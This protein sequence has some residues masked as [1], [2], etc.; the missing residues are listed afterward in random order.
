MKLQ[1]IL[2]VATLVVGLGVG[3]AAQKPKTQTATGPVLKIAGDSLTID[4]GKGGFV[5][6]QFEV[7][8][9]PELRIRARQGYFLQP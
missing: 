4:A 8:K 2:A 5:P 7:D 3:V 6:I 1:A 9:R